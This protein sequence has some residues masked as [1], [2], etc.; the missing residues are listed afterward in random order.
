VTEH[1]LATGHGASLA[2]R[3]NVTLTSSNDFGS[4]R[5]RAENDQGTA[6]AAA[7][8]YEVRLGASAVPPLIRGREPLVA[9]VPP[10]K[11]ADVRQLCPPPA[12]IFSDPALLGENRGTNGIGKCGLVDRTK[13]TIV[14]YEG[15]LVGPGERVE[16]ERATILACV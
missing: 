9:G 5:C 16:G 12:P 11:F 4:Y 6:V 13:M 2:L 14:P 15:S 10:P 3:L 7:E 8:L 1:P